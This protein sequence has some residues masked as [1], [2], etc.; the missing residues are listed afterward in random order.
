MKIC[1]KFELPAIK[2]WDK[3]SPLLDKKIC[4]FFLIYCYPDKQ[5]SGF[6]DAAFGQM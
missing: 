1:K 3:Y 6:F 2:N 5:K 4:W